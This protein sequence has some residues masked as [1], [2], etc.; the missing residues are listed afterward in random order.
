MPAAPSRP[1]A[2]Q[3]SPKIRP[4]HHR[5]LSAVFIEGSHQDVRTERLSRRGKPQNY[6]FQSSKTYGLSGTVHVPWVRWFPRA[7]DSA[8]RFTGSARLPTPRAQFSYLLLLGTLVP[9]RVDKTSS[10]HGVS[11]PPYCTDHSPKKYHIGARSPLAAADCIF[12]S[13]LKSP[14]YFQR[15]LRRTKPSF[16]TSATRYD[17]AS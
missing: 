10:V 8:I 6:Y 12:G 7:Q 16:T 17:T 13:W 4:S 3:F 9:V 5:C 15:D 14:P 11:P 1:R 2:R